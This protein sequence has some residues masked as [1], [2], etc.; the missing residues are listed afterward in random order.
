[1]ALRWLEGFDVTVSSVGD[2][3]VSRYAATTLPTVIEYVSGRYSGSA[4]RAKSDPFKLTTP[5]FDD[6][7][8]WT[9]GFHLLFRAPETI[10]LLT[11][12]RGGT[13]QM[14]VSVV[15]DGD[16]MV[17]SLK[18]GAT[19]LATYTIDVPDDWIH[20][21]LKTTFH[22]TA[23]AYELRLN[24]ITVLAATNQNTANTGSNDA[25][26]V[27]LWLEVPVSSTAFMVIDN[28]YVLDGSGTSN[29]TFLGDSAIEEKLVFAPGTFTEW[30]P[31]LEGQVNAENVDDVGDH[32]GNTTYNA[33]DTVNLTDTFMMSALNVLITVA[34]VQLEIVGA[35]E[36]AA[37]SE[38]IKAITVVD[39]VDHASDTLTL[40]SEEPDY[41]AVHW[42]WDVNPETDDPWTPEVLAAVEFGYRSIA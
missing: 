25:D 9:I 10:D 34:G 38:D 39:T 26:Q 3:L 32:D 37:G 23:G 27:Q 8:T 30:A 22:T 16:D 19:V 18:R 12:Y 20:F 21:E 42:V 7:A 1:M 13:A 41:Q 31:K 4:I 28:W 14:T 36:V 40:T 29:T 33:A 6:H 11:F 15:P 24:G 5:A 17:L 2:G 35:I